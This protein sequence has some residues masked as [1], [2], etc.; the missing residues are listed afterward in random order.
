MERLHLLLPTLG[1][2]V[3]ALALQQCGWDEERA[4]TMLRRFQ[5][6]GVC[7]AGV[8]GSE[9]GWRQSAASLSLAD[10]RLLHLCLA[11]VA[12]TCCVLDLKPACLALPSVRYQLCRCASMCYLIELES[13]EV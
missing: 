11:G 10:W 4:L 12:D 6:S 5:V 13:L 8:V 7:W 3:R 2:A 9:L 1:T